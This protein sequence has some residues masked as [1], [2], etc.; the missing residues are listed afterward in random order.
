MRIASHVTLAPLAALLLGITTTACGGTEASKEGLNPGDAGDGGPAD[1]DAA[2]DAAE[3]PEAGPTLVT[4]PLYAC[5]PAIYTAGTT[6]GGQDFQ[7]TVD[8]GST[9]LGVAA[10]TC[11]SCGTSPDYKPGSTAVD[12][13]VQQSSVYGTGQWTGEVYQDDVALLPETA[14]PLPFVAIDTQTGFFPP[15]NQPAYCSS[16]SG[17]YQGIVGLAPAGSALPDTTGYFDQVVSTLGVADVFA[18][19]LC[20]TTGKLWL[21]GWDPTATTA[22]PVYT[23]LLG[24]EYAGYYA[25]NLVSLTISGQTIQVS[26]SQFP[27]SIVDT[28]T[29]VFIVPTAAFNAIASTVAAIPEFATI[30]GSMGAA[31]FNDPN[32]CVTPTQTKAELDAIFPPITLTFGSGSSAVSIQAAATES[33]FVEYTIQGQSLWCP[34]LDAMNASNQFPVASIMGAPLLRSNVVIFDR[35]NKQVG[36]APHAACK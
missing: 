6:I 33:Y 36:F 34:S 2:V 29:S 32:N 31:W 20:P 9:T 14:V 28:G 4:V 21:G 30:F 23:P 8:T 11:T 16:K 25:V 19:E 26:N 10:S 5:V 15:A 3:E 17:S 24:N 22:P 18:T 12:K 13:H 7:L 1:E 35:A 27:G